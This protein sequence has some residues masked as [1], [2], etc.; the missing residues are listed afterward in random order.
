[1][2]EHEK[3]FLND[4][5]T[6]IFYKVGKKVKFDDSTARTQTHQ[7]F[8]SGGTN[9]AIF[10]QSQ[11]ITFQYNGMPSQIMHLASNKSGIR[12][13]LKLLT[14]TTGVSATPPGSALT[15]ADLAL[16]SQVANITLNSTFWG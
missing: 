2:S 9:D 7:F 1:M 12:T 15:P 10:N 14:G 13:R 5:T 16:A 8:P 3:E 11:D 6:P 4:S